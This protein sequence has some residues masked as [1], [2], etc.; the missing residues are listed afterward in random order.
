MQM[1]ISEYIR[2]L[3]RQRGMTQTEL[4][5]EHFSKSYVSAIEREKIVPSYEALRFFAEQLDQP[6]DDFKRLVEQA[7][8]M[9]FSGAQAVPA[10]SLQDE[11][12]EQDESTALLG[13]ML[14]GIELPRA[15]FSQEISKLP[16]K[17]YCT[18]HYKSRRVIA[19]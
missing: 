16:W 15:S 9:E 17:H 11:N 12:D 10:L 7:V 4:G 2:L 13:M 5:G 8:L 6:V 14:E 19:C 1:P 3:R 18:S